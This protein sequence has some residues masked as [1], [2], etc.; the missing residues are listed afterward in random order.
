MWLYVDILK[1]FL[2]SFQNESIPNTRTTKLLSGHSS[3]SRG[4]QNLKE[5]NV[6]IF[7]EARNSPIHGTFVGNG[8]WV[9][10]DD[11]RRL[12]K[13]SYSDVELFW[14]TLWRHVTAAW[15]NNVLN[16]QTVP[17]VPRSDLEF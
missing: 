7:K 10:D 2:F 9:T 11:K 4:Q 17:G 14:H 16:V 5:V 1:Y 13:K 12:F 8:V 15:P 6:P 3:F